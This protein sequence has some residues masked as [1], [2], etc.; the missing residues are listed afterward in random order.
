M[1]D[2]GDNVLIPLLV[3]AAMKGNGSNNPSLV[4]AHGDV[5]GGMYEKLK[6]LGEFGTAY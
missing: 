1:A 2:D 5:G 6:E 3:S 4:V